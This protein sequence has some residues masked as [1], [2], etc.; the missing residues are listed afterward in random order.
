MAPDHD[1]CTRRGRLGACG[2]RPRDLHPQGNVR[3]H[4]RRCH[5]ARLWAASPLP[6]GFGPSLTRSAPLRLV[7]CTQLQQRRTTRNTSPARAPAGTLPGRAPPCGT[8]CKAACPCAHPSGSCGVESDDD[9]FSAR[10]GGWL[11]GRVGT[12]GVSARFW[13]AGRRRACR[14]QSSGTCRRCRWRAAL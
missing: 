12:G 10:C 2:A 8:T 6:A 1:A 11:T 9:R 3:G 13:C 5:P 7:P 4:A 14:H